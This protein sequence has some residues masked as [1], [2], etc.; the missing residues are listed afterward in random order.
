[1]P[2]E[3]QFGP[4]QPV[5]VSSAANCV[6]SGTPPSAEW[7]HA[8]LICTVAAPLYLPAWKQ[9]N[10]DSYVNRLGGIEA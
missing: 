10:R 4:L 7:T 6:C 9:E 3:T 8:N 1:V 2:E 5:S